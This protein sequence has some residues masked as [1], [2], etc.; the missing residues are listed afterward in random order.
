MTA[1]ENLLAHTKYGRYKCFCLSST[2]YLGD[3][4]GI[5]RHMQLELTPVMN[6]NQRNYIFTS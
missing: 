2:R 1:V 3:R 4:G 6:K 5:I